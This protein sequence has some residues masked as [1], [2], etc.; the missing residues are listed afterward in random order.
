M[1]R[2][3]RYFRN[4]VQL[5]LD[6]ASATGCWT[7]QWEGRGS[8]AP[9][10]GDDVHI[11]QVQLTMQLEGYDAVPVERTVGFVVLLPRRAGR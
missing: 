6:R 5:P 8:P 3:R 10:W 2:Q 11:P 9:R 1:A 7:E 4:L